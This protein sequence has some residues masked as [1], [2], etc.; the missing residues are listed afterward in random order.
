MMPGKIIFVN[1]TSSAGKSTICK[2]LRSEFPSYCYFASDQLAVEGFRPFIRS[3]EER[4]RFFDGFHRSIASFVNA[5]CDMIVEHIVEESE[6]MESLDQLLHSVHIYWVGVY[7]S[8]EHLTQREI[9]RGNRTVGEALYHVKTHQYCD[10][11]YNVS[12]HTD[13]QSHEEVIKAIVD[14][15]KAWEKSL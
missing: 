8:E 6:W 15:F 12:V 13:Q 7:C 5:G 11:K 10:H 2:S 9:D 1:G 3:D 4:I 14:G